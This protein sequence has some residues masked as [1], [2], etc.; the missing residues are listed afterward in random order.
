MFGVFVLA[1]F[2]VLLII[3]ALLGVNGKEDPKHT[4]S[5][6]IIQIVQEKELDNDK[7]NPTLSEMI[8]YHKKNSTTEYKI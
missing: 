2:S 3:C 6:K 7:D 5:K 1:L 4:A 8:E